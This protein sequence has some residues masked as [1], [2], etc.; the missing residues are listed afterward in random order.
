MS[1]GTTLEQSHI[2]KDNGFKTTEKDEIVIAFNNFSL[3]LGQ[4][5]QK[6]NQKNTWSTIAKLL[7]APS[8][9]KEPTLTWKH[10]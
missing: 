4:S 7:K 3:T 10:N 2:I 5:S 8:G 9:L 6:K 1:R